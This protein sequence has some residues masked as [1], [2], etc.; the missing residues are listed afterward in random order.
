MKP[1]FLSALV[2]FALFANG[3]AL[4]C[5]DMKLTDDGDGV[6]M[7]DRSAATTDQAPAPKAVA[8]DTTTVKQKA[9]A[10]QKPQGK[11]LNQG[12]ATLVK[13]GI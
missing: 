1:T 9:A 2:V 8:I 6:R 5:D 11:P 12:G 10:K 4:A 13:T 3:A 7:R